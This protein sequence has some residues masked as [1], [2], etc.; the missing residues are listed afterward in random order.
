MTYLITFCFAKAGNQTILEG[1]DGFDVLAE[2]LR[3]RD[4]VTEATG[5]SPNIACYG[6]HRRWLMSYMEVLGEFQKEYRCNGDFTIIFI[7]HLIQR[8]GFRRREHREA[9]LD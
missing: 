5:P 1:P 9:R 7:E 8:H 6:S 4:A 3:W 2:W